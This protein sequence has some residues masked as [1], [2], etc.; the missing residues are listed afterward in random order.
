MRHSYLY[1]IFILVFSFLFSITSCNSEKEIERL[2]REQR[3][4]K[5]IEDSL[6][7]KIAILPSSDCDFIRVADSLG[8]FDSLG[9][10]VHLRKY[11]A[12]SECRYALKHKMVEGAV[13]DSSLAETIQKVDT[14]QLTL[15]RSTQLRWKMVVSKKSRV[16]RYGQLADKVIATD[17]HGKS[18]D[19]ASQAIDSIKKQKKDVFIIQC[20]DLNI[21]LKMIL[22]G[23]VDGAMLPEPYA[24]TALHS[25]CNELPLNNDNTYGVIAFRSPVLKDKRIKKQHDLFLEACAMAESFI[26][27]RGSR[28]KTDNKKVSDKKADTNDVKSLKTNTN[29]EEKNKK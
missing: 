8:Y 22:G 9:V 6:S 2:T 27:E 5:R 28:V 15:S 13:I 21:R 12:L 25:G 10:S 23:N 16:H 18:H 24:T 26:K 19:L 29:K 7:L 4:Q 1:T 20:E 17:S 11:N 14:T 3:E